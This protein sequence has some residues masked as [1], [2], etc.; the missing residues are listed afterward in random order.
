MKKIAIKKLLNIFLSVIISVWFTYWILSAWTWLTATDWDTLTAAK[1]N[2]LVSKVEQQDVYSAE[3]TLTNKI[4]MWKP[5]YR[6]VIQDLSTTVN[7]S[8][9]NV[10]YPDYDWTVVE[11]ILNSEVIWKK[12]WSY[13]WWDWYSYTIMDTNR[14]LLSVIKKDY[15][16][17]YLWALQPPTSVDIIIEYTKT[18]D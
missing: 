16:R 18:T 10:S 4:W 1:W 8:W 13:Y 9:T 11:Y 5:V 14:A 7:N 17:Y 3:E 6:R 15:F 12:D 2:E